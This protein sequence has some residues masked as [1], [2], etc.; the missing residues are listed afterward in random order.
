M[1]ALVGMALLSAAALLLQVALTRV[2]SVA[3]FYHFAFLVVSLALLG[4]GASG[5]VLAVWPSLRQTAW[6]PWFALGFALTAVL[7]YLFVNHHAF[8]SYSIA[9]DSDQAWL[10]IANLLFLA[11]PFAFA[12]LLIASMLAE[13]AAGAGRVYAANLLGSAAGSVGAIV[14]LGWLSSAQAVL[15]CA[16]LGSIAGV[17]LA[18]GRKRIALGTC[19]VAATAGIAL[20]LLLPP[21]FE[22]QTSPY[23]TLSQIRLD[24]EA[25]IVR[26][27]ENASARLDVVRSPTIHSAQGLSLGYL[28]ELPP[29]A[30]LVVDAGMLLPVSERAAT[31]TALLEHM[32]SAVAYRL[33]PDADVL[34]LGSG[35]GIEA[36]TALANTS[37]QVTVVEPNELVA[38]ALRDDLAEWAGLA[39]D[40]RVTLLSE[41]IRTAAER[42]DD[43]PDVVVLSLTEGYHPV[44][45]G[46]FTLTEDYTLTT[47]AFEAYLDLL[48]PDGLL[49]VHRWLQEPPSETV[50]TL[51]TILAAL[52]VADPAEHIA[53][54]R[55]FQHG[56][57]VVKPDGFDEGEVETLL[58]GV[59]DLRYDLTLAP[60][61]PQELVNRSARLPEPVYADTYRA[62]LETPD[63]AAF[64][65]AQPFEVTPT[66]D[67]RPFFFHFFRAEQTPDVLEN[68]GRRWQP[69]GGSGYFVLVALL[70][71]AVM[72]ALLFVLLPVVLRRRFRDGLRVIGRGR[73]AR[74]VGYFTLLGLAF[75][76][77]EISLIQGFILLLGQPTLAVAT[78]IGALLLASG[79]GS[80]L[81]ARCD[82]RLVLVALA[83][84]LVIYPV[85]VSTL[86]PIL[87]PLPLAARMLAVALLIT[88]V[89]FLMGMPFP[90]GVAALADAD[91]VVPWAWAAN[92]SASVVSA[93]LAAMLALSFG[94]GAVLLIGAALY[95]GAAAIRPTP[96]PTLA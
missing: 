16:V 43:A 90:R 68:L 6:R 31:D 29:Q 67:D 64:F 25:E 27:A 65:A 7:A 2:F 74:V 88:P 34:I 33:R 84:L 40:P 69:F 13:H 54:F 30:G 19:S 75:L 11:V 85:V 20:L 89:G 44:S 36:L 56:T 1:R 28:G 81:S 83:A 45:S 24:P 53:A 76:L 95:L 21:T 3:Q 77:V 78:V 15:L 46:A 86:T 41:E 92:G 73:A 62:L 22:V 23:K 96:R 91:D 71:F 93:V 50:R 61:M 60:Q 32:P 18:E 48:A 82:W 37:G 63:R 5:T 94:F 9:W 72:A 59:E 10:L 58:A 38:E 52:D 49:I 80:S 4:F 26:T 17:V 14:V 79:V 35:G 70:A 8:D 42:T 55:S 12:G 66:T 47:E 57:F 87:L 39:D 51:A